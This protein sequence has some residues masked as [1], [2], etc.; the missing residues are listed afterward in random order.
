MNPLYTVFFNTVSNGWVAGSTGTILNTTNGGYDTFIGEKGPASQDFTLYPNP[1]SNSIYLASDREV[2]GEI[3]AGIFSI[4]GQLIKSETFLNRN[5]VEMDVSL[6][7]PGIYFIQVK[8]EEGIL[9]KKLI[10]R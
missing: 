8:S 7:T 4:Q 6:L 2:H 10:I 3:I 9:L 5:P 1:A